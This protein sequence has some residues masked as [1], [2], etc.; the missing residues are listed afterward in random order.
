MASVSSVSVKFLLAQFALYALAAF[1][2]GV[3]VGFLWQRRPVRESLDRVR[4]LEKAKIGVDVRLEQAERERDDVRASASEA[5]AALA[6][7][8]ELRAATAE[9]IAERH[10]AIAAK[11]AAEAKAEQLRLDI[12]RR[13]APV[14]ADHGITD[15]QREHSAA[16]AQLRAEHRRELNAQRIEA[17]SR[18]RENASTLAALRERIASL[19]ADRRAMQVR[20]NEFVRS[21]QIEI[22]NATVRAEQA[23]ARL[24]VSRSTGLHLPSDR[25]RE[26]VLDLR[27]EIVA[28]STTSP[29]AE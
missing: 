3:A 4:R 12:D 28:S 18:E 5:A 23:E 8:A 15:L 29:T 6:T 9:A 13:V 21:S 14:F 17:E 1:A 11:D 19:E 26:V 7:V 2:L 16:L 24:S 10:A 27:D 22:T 25:G 20:H